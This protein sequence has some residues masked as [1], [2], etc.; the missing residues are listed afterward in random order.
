MCRHQDSP[1]SV[2]PPPRKPRD[3]HP[4]AS[5]S[6]HDPQGCRKRGMPRTPVEATPCPARPSVLSLPLGRAC[7]HTWHLCASRESLRRGPERQLPRDAQLPG[8][9]MPLEAAPR[10]LSSPPLHPPWRAQDHTCHRHGA[11]TGVPSETSEKPP[12]PAVSTQDDRCTSVQLKPAQPTAAQETRQLLP[13]RTPGP[14]AARC[15][16]HPPRLWALLWTSHGRPGC[17]RLVTAAGPDFSWPRLVPQRLGEAG[18]SAPQT[19][20]ITCAAGSHPSRGTAGPCFLPHYLQEGSSHR[21]AVP[22]QGCPPPRQNPE[23]QR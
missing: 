14:R 6:R 8:G 21:R 17:P 9:L 5:A 12:S 16:A 22:L 13:P 15:A 18:L 1:P 2:T 7:A 20:P 11:G 19:R 10:A 4:S 23:S 3:A